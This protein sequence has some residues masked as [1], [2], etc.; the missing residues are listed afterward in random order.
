MAITRGATGRRPTYSLSID[1]AATDTMVTDITGGSGVVW[2]IEFVSGSGAVFLRFYNS[3]SPVLG[4]TV[5]LMT[6]MVPASTTFS[7]VMPDGIPFTEAISYC[8][9][10]DNSAPQVTTAPSASS[11]LYLTAS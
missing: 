4:T 5:P 1:T 2:A 6:F 3:S 11:T 10:G 7:C 8:V 9:T